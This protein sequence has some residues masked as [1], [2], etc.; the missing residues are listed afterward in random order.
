MSCS[1]INDLIDVGEGKGSLGQALLRSLKST[2]R[3]QDLSFF[4]TITRFAS[5]SGCIIFLMN[6]ASISLA[7]SSPNSLTFGF[8]KAPQCLFDRF[9]SLQYIEVVFG[10]PVWDSRHIRR[11]PGEYVLVLA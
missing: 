2:H 5:Q 1:S 8:G 9:I 4:G 11:V 3:R 10:Q 6:P 7:S